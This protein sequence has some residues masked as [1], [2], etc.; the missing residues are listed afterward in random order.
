MI[1]GHRAQAGSEGQAPGS[2]SD[3]RSEVRESVRVEGEVGVSEDDALE[4]LIASMDDEPIPEID[5]GVT[6]DQWAM[7]EP[8]AVELQPG[9]EERPPA[10]PE[11]KC[12]IAPSQEEFDD[13]CRRGHVQYRTWCPVCVRSRGREDPH[14]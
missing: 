11:L 14:R 10:R 12:P 2:S 7:S 4:E 3:D 13:H 1:S 6:E 8:G 5:E 9:D